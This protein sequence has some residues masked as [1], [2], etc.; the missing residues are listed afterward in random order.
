MR[1]WFEAV[2][3]DSKPFCCALGVAEGALSGGACS[4]NGWVGELLAAKDDWGSA[5]GAGLP[6]GVKGDVS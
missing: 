3:G 2:D 6:P 5:I 4:L 1:L